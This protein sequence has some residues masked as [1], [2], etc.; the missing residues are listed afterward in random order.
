M[1]ASHKGL[2]FFIQKREESIDSM[3]EILKQKDRGLIARIYDTEVGNMRPE[4]KTSDGVL[5]GFIE[6]MKS[7]TGVKREIKVSDIFDLRFV[8]KADEELKASGWK[9]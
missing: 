4:G 8:S 3:M 5:Q 2:L 1:R 7:T 9:P 6:D